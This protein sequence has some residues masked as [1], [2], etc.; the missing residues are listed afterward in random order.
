MKGNLQPWVFDFLKDIWLCTIYGPRL[1]KGTGAMGA[2]RGQSETYFSFSF[3]LIL[4]S[5]ISKFKILSTSSIGT[6]IQFSVKKGMLLQIGRCKLKLLSPGA[7]FPY[8]GEQPL[9][10]NFSIANLG[11]YNIHNQQIWGP[12]NIPKSSSQAI[13]F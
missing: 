6:P 7:V 9:L 10:S 11:P 13:Q 2:H 1:N 3:L 5:V 12:H 8:I 4:V